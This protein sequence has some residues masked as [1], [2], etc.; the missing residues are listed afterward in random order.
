MATDESKAQFW[1]DLE[2]D[3]EDPEFAREYAAAAQD[4]RDRQRAAREA[5]EAELDPATRYEGTPDLDEVED[6][7]NE[8]DGWI[9]ELTEQA[10][11]TADPQLRE[12][13]LRRAWILRG[14]AEA[15]WHYLD[16]N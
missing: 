3:M 12:L 8:L 15:A 13:L 1:R 7:G 9:D 2:R 6:W 16:L 10:E 11:L 14:A 5:A 4:I